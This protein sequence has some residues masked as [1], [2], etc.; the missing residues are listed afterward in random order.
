MRPSGVEWIGDIPDEWTISRVKYIPDGEG[1]LFQ[2]GDWIESPVIV[3]S[4]IR[5]LTTGNIGPGYYKEQGWGHISERTF[6]EMDCLEVHP[7]DILISRL[8]QPIGRCCLAPSI[9]SRFVVA[10]DVCVLRPGRDW[11]R[12]YLVYAM[13]TDGYAA[14]GELLSRG[15]TMQRVSRTLLG[16]LEVPHPPLKIQEQISEILDAKTD[17]L[18]AAISYI[19]HEISTLERYKSSL[20]HEAVTKGLDRDVPMRPSGV[21][22]IGDIPEGWCCERAAFLITNTQNGISRRQY[23]ESSGTIVLRIK[24]I[25]VD[26]KISYAGDNRIELSM[27]E[28]RQYQLHDGDFIFVRVNGSRSLV[29]KCGIHHDIDEPVAFNDHIIR[30]SFDESRLVERFAYYYLNSDCGKTDIDGRIKTS[31]GQYTVSS[32]DI[33]QIR[34]PLPPIEEQE[35]IVAYLD[36]RCSRIDRILDLKRRQVDVLRRRRQS[37]IYEYVTGKRRVGQEA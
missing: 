22:W 18:D 37:L 30:V 35:Q 31:A 4:G 32:F 2:D 23:G 21:E 27:G 26:G 6:R 10:V 29:G 17:K 9:E 7:G 25:G 28:L 19:E 14:S 1:S 3:S 12:R 13:N 11:S 5:Y 16:N 20:I 24:D 36:D 15:A 8:N 34:F 33:K